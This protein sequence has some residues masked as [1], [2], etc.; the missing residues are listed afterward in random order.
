MSTLAEFL[1]PLA[2]FDAWIILAAAGVI[3]AGSFVKGAIGFALPTIAFAFITMFLTPQE[4]IGVMILPLLV[5]NLWQMVRQGLPAAWETFA[6]Y[7]RLNLVLAGL[8]GFVAQLVPKLSPELLVTLLGL[9]VSV[10]AAL[11]LAGWRP[12]APGP[13]RTRH[14]LELA[15]GA[16]GGVIGGLTGVW[17]PPVLFYLIARATPKTEQIRCQGIVF[18][19][20]SV[21]LVGAHLKSGVVNE[22]TLPFSI[23]MLVP[24]ALGMV[25]GLRAQ[26]GMDQERFRRWTLIVLCVAGLNLLRQGLT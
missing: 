12:T 10:T 5:S 24:M 20:G 6:K 15:T 14:R 17:G 3:F 13:G 23:L 9:V 8:I 16:A 22:V 11:Q 21:V 26:D 1:Q 2:A 4:T 25:L 18:F 19:L 7:W